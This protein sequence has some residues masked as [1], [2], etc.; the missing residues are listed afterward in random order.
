LANVVLNAFT[1][2]VP[3]GT[4]RAVSSAAEVPAGVVTVSIVDQ[5]T[6]LTMSITTR[7]AIPA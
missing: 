5:S 6:G 2:F 7:P 3:S 4:S 1:T